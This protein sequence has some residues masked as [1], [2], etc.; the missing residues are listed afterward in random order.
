SNFGSTSGSTG[1]QFGGSEP[2]DSNFGATSPNGN[3]GS[4]SFGSQGLQGSFGSQGLQG[5]FGSRGSLGSQESF[6]SQGAGIRQYLPPKPSSQN[7]PQQPFDEKFG[8]IY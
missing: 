1:S 4:N 7:P 5:S 8:Y 3:F 6:G 2:S